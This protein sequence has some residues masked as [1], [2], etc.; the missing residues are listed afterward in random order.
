MKLELIIDK[1]KLQ[2]VIN[3]IELKYTDVK[4]GQL[5]ITNRSQLA[6]I[7]SNT[8][9]AINYKPKPIT[10]AVVTARIRKFGLVC[11]TPLGKRG[12]QKG[13]AIVRSN[14]PKKTSTEANDALIKYM[15]PKYKSLA[16]KIIGGSRQAATKAMCIQCVGF[17]NA[18]NEIR[19]CTVFSCPL[20]NFR[21]Y[22]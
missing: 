10:A 17:E 21:P 5:T 8:E 6:D 3:D 2:D 14:K 16:N 22:K 19:N 18:A 9:W 4:T 12:R 1:K 11:K 20:F 15:T 13:E 7:V